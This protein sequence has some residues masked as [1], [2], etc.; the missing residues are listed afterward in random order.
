MYEAHE[1]N[2]CVI[3]LNDELVA[4]LGNIKPLDVD[5]WDDDNLGYHNVKAANLSSAGLM[6]VEEQE[7][8]FMFEDDDL[9]IAQGVSAMKRVGFVEDLSFCKLVE[10][11]YGE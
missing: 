1:L 9:S 8:I 2:F 5:K 3:Y 6:S 11:N 7:G 4:V 10:E